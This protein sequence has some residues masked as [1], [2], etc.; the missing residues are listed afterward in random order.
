MSNYLEEINEEEIK[1]TLKE[2]LEEGELN[3]KDLFPYPNLKTGL[4]AKYISANSE[5]L[6]RLGFFVNQDGNESELSRS[7]TKVGFEIYQEIE[8]E[9]KKNIKSMLRE[10][11][12]KTENMGVEEVSFLEDKKTNIS[13][14]F[15]EVSLTYKIDKIIERSVFELNNSGK[16]ITEEK[17]FT[18]YMPNN[19]KSYDI[20]AFYFH[21]EDTKFYQNK[22]EKNFL[23]MN[24]KGEVKLIPMAD[25][26]DPIF[27][28]AEIVVEP[29]SKQMSFLEEKNIE[30][31]KK[32]E[33]IKKQMGLEE[34]VK[35][36]INKKVNKSAKN[37]M[38]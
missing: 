3:F 5:N 36:V 38:K 18:R 11:Y 27:E 4:V 9:L 26:G 14:M 31:N 10:W 21:L 32:Q 1:E 33:K 29:S 24:A 20:E 16:K 12:F 2:M 34:T 22:T 7:L 17:A 35:K 28:N 30:N 15:G 6:R 19:K 37:N 13:F 23:G 25:N 8:N